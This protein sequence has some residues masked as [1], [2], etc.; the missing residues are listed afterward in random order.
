MPFLH[1]SLFS[2]PIN[3]N[4]QSFILMFLYELSFLEALISS[5]TNLITCRFVVEFHFSVFFQNQGRDTES[6]P[7]LNLHENL[8]K[9]L[10]P[11]LNK[12][13]RFIMF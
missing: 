10:F 13:K 9:K 4:S 3:F 6:N 1:W 11:I 12:A 2:A 5:T 8:K 7:P